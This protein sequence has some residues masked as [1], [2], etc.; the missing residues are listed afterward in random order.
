M[1]KKVG[2]ASYKV[3]GGKLIQCEVTYHADNI[4]SVKYSGDFFMHPEDAIEDLE[5]KLKNIHIKEIEKTIIEFFAM[6]NIELFGVSPEDFVK[7]VHDAI[8]KG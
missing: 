1:N 8:N 5:N 3:K 4:K 7:I 2:F 6:R